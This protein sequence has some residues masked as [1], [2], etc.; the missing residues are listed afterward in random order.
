VTEL[1]DGVREKAR[2]ITALVESATPDD[3]AEL[4]VPWIK[5]DPDLVAQVI[6]G[7]AQM[8]DRDLALKEAHAAYGRGERTPTVIALESRY[9]RNRK[10]KLREYEAHKEEAE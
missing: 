6:V 2:M 3:V 8:S 4:L 10:R 1:T 7:L 9:Q 5:S